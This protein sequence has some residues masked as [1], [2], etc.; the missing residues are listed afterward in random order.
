MCGKGFLDTTVFGKVLMKLGLALLVVGHLNFIVGAIVHGLVLRH[1]IKLQDMVSLQYSITNTLTVVSAILSLS[2][3][4]ATIVLSQYLTRRPLGWSILVLAVVN[5]LVS[6]LCT[7]GLIVSVV[8]TFSN[9]GRTLLASCTF[10]DLDLIQI[11]HECPFDPTR[12]YSTSLCL[13][14]ISIFLD[15]MEVVFSIRLLV[16]ILQL[17]ELKVCSRTKV[18]WQLSSEEGRPLNNPVELKLGGF[19]ENS[20]L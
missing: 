13:W 1:V 9:E 4:I 11:S 16:K 5:I 18:T 8:I 14:A 17:L 3:G 12:I 6:A 15:I 19:E 7:V 2:C 10:I 20:C